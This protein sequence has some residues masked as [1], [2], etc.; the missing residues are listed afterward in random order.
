[1]AGLLRATGPGTFENMQ[2]AAFLAE[3]GDPEWYSLLLEV[4]EKHADIADY[5]DDAAESGGDE[6][7]PLLL[8]LMHNPDKQFI[9]ANAI[10]AL[11]YTGSRAAVPIL[12]DLLRSPDPS[13]SLRA[14]YGLRQLTHRTIPGERWFENPQSQYPVWAQWWNRE[15][16][17]APIYKATECKEM[18]LLN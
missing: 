6:A 13:T 1:M 9:Q 15:G 18:N 7:L 3:T 5:V 12:L 17:N 4:G 2:S 14:L 16:V 11:G 10:S 8:S